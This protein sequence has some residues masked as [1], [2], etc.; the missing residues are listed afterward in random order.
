MVAVFNVFETK[1]FFEIA[2]FSFKIDESRRSVKKLLIND[3][4]H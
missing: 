2:I 1:V 3:E 4:V